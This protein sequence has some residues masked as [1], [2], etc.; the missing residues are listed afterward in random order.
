MNAASADVKCTAGGA[1]CCLSWIHHLLQVGEGSIAALS[2]GGAVSKFGFPLQ[3]GVGRVSMQASTAW[4]CC[5]QGM[6]AAA[7]FASRS[8]SLSPTCLVP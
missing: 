7:C 5:T 4:P 3:V 1:L 8:A 2:T 6:Q